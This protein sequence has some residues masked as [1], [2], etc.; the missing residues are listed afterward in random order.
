MDQQTPFS[1]PGIELWLV[2]LQAPAREREA[3]APGDWLDEAERSRA[4][5]FH[6]ERDAHRYRASHTA[7]RHLLAQRTGVAPAALRFAA[8]RHDKPQLD[9]PG[10]PAFNMSHSG[11][12]ALIGIGGQ[13]PIGVDIEAPR[14]MDDLMALAERNFTASECAELLALPEAGRLR[15][16]LRCWTRKEA[17]LKAVGSG[18]SIEPGL[19]EAGTTPE[20]RTTTLPVSGQACEVTVVSVDV[21]CEALAAVAW[22]EPGSR[23]LAF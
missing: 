4:A 5:R 20:R 3:P 9:L 21:D 13:A 16:F 10:A 18:L 6:F 17:C 14:E 1:A 12:W 23:H 7:L 2:D 22:V 11:R 19:F 8:G 15:A